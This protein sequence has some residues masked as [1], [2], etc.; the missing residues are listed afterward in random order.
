MPKVK[1]PKKAS[2]YRHINI[3]P[4][5]DKVLKLVVKEEIKIYL[6]KNDIITKH[7]S[8]FRKRYSFETALQMIMEEANNQ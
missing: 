2:E 3:L 4:I 1:K 6:K 5:Y 8:G 7:Q